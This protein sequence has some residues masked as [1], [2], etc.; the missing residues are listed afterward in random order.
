MSAQQKTV[1]HLQSDA[2]LFLF[3]HAQTFSRLQGVNNM[4][5]QWGNR[6]ALSKAIN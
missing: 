4:R 5:G 3:L 1:T 2:I 6:E